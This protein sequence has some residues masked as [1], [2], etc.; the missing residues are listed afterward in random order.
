MYSF[1]LWNQADEEEVKMKR[2][3]PNCGS[4]IADDTHFC[5]NCGTNV[6]AVHGNAGAQS[7]PYVQNKAG[8]QNS[9]YAPV[10]APVVKTQG[11]SLSG[12]MKP[13]LQKWAGNLSKYKILGL[14]GC[15]LMLIANWMPWVK[16]EALGM[17]ASYSL[18][19]IYQ[20]E[21]DIPIALVYV[22]IVGLVL[23]AVFYLMA[24]ELIFNA[25]I[26]WLMGIA[27]LFGML[28]GLIGLF[29]LAD[30]MN[31]VWSAPM[32]FSLGAFVMPVGCIMVV[33]ADIQ[34]RRIRRKV[35]KEMKKAGIN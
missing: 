15:V 27:F 30:A 13:Y 12:D 5:G 31:S 24:N 34:L 14:V 20:N 2:F 33:I 3:C 25:A 7:S 29:A 6:A 19:T 28:P 10:P 26:L 9:H 8:A 32:S 21:K 1:D 35:K 16:M 4:E 17:K 18:Y 22:G 11:R 23:C